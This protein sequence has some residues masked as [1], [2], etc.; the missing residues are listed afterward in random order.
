M[1]ILAIGNS[2]SMN[3]T[4]NLN[5]LFALNHYDA[6]VV[7][8]YIPGCSLKTHAHNLQTNEE[9]YEYQVD[10]ICQKKVGLRTV[11]SE[12]WDVITL[13]QFSGESGLIKTYYPYINELIDYLKKHQPQA[14]LVLHKTW[15][16]EKDCDHESYGHYDHSQQRMN[17]MIDQTAKEIQKREGLDVILAADAVSVIRETKELQDIPMCLDG[18]HLNTEFGKYVGALIWLYFFYPEATKTD[19]ITTLTPQVLELTNILVKEVVSGHQ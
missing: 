8:L 16:Y 19:I 18:Y 6:Q 4:E 3:T 1:K 2:F 14:R 11:L 15:S 13:Q 17:E 10:A 9:V 7:N 5:R 12:P